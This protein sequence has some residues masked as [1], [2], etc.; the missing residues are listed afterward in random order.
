MNIYK[1]GVQ[2]DRYVPSYGNKK[3]LVAIDSS[4]TNTAIAVGDEY[5]NVLDD[6]EISGA[7]KDTDVYDLCKVTRVQL[8]QLFED[9][10]ILRV[11]I[12]DII[13][14]KEKGYKGLDVHQS[15]AKITAVFD[16]F[17]FLFDD[18]FGIRPDRINNWTWKSNVLPE[19]YR[20]KEHDKGSKDWFN[21]LNN[22][23][24]GRK[25]DVTDAV[26]ILM[27]LYQSTDIK[28]ISEIKETA[29]S[30]VPYMV[31]LV[32]VSF[33]VSASGLEF[34]ISNSDSLEHNL[35]T[36][37]GRLKNGQVGYLI[38]DLS[39]VPVDWIYSDRL[40]YS[41]HMMYDRVTRQIKI[42]IERR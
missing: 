25:D 10:I 15:R 26:C 6:Y 23:W 34:V 27:Y 4:K 36:I 31:A 37:A 20:S 40:R 30:D 7:G 3:I 17:M 28:H 16:N 33:D 41:D 18:Y 2:V 24:A 35:E 38:V 1:N 5:G 8:K 14:K 19:E 13:T 39:Q 9:A 29:P 22:R 42:L 11:G 12:E 21:D 32:P